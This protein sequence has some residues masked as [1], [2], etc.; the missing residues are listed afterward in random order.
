VK[1][2]PAAGAQAKFAR[3]RQ[4]LAEG[5]SLAVACSGGVDSTFLLYAAVKALPPD[6]VSAWHCRSA[7]ASSAALAGCRQI[8]GLEVFAQIRRVE[9]VVDPFTWEGFAENH[10]NRCYICKKGMYQALQ[11]TLRDGFQLADGTNLDDLSQHRP[12]LRAL[13]ELRVL[14]PLVDAGLTKEEIRQLAEDAGLPNHHWP[15]DSCLATRIVQGSLITPDTLSCI[16]KAEEFVKAR[17]FFGC[18]VRL[19][20]SVAVVELAAADISRFAEEANRN[21]VLEYFRSLAIDLVHLN[22]SGR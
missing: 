16:E 22:L 8:F 14:T 13:R 4:L 15:A 2:P 19:S 12:G 17:G 10:E 9:L 20:G 21:K 1:T 6:R 11:N 3:L 7:L 5:P 18:R